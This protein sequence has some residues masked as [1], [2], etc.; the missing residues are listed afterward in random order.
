MAGISIRYRGARRDNSP[1]LP[2]PPGRVG[3]GGVALTTGPRKGAYMSR[4]LPA[5]CV[6][7]LATPRVA[8]ADKDIVIEIPGERT[9]EQKILVGSLAGAGALAGA[10][11]A[12]FH[13]DSRDAANEVS[14]DTYTGHAWTA[15]DESLVDRAD[16]SRTRAIVGY[17]VGGAL[18]IG[19]IVAFIVTDPPSETAVIR[20]H[21][22]GSV[23]VTPT[24]GGAV[25]FGTWS[26]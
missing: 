12:Y 19:A 9:M 26:F 3:S 11:G 24:E 1:I 8:R 6:L 20:P 21:G 22:R 25:A 7:A 13:L 15:E 14:S 4:L 23:M 2:Y 16:R 17:S 5:I 18:L 10:I